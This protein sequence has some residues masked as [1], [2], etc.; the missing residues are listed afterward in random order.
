MLMMTLQFVKLIFQR[1]NKSHNVAQQEVRGKP[2]DTDCQ[3]LRKNH[4]T[5]S[6]YPVCKMCSSCAS[7]NNA[8]VKQSKRKTYNYLRKM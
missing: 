3:S 8:K 2:T 7:Q 6:R 4:F 1:C 5:P